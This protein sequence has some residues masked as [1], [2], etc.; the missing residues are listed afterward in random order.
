MYFVLIICLVFPVNLSGTGSRI[1]WTIA[2][3]ILSAITLF[4]IALM[5]ILVRRKKAQR[6]SLED[7]KHVYTSF[8]YTDVTAFESEGPVI[9]S[10]E[11]IEDATSNFEETKIIG[12]GGYGCVY[13][14]ILGR[15]VPALLCL[16]LIST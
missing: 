15:K 5:I 9:Y 2:V 4:S 1:K 6:V 12:T 3:V 11:E 8:A 13:L 16:L 7:Q 10:L 14:G